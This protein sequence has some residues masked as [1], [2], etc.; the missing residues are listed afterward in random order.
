MQYF[1]ADTHFKHQN[2]LRLSNRPFST[3]EEHDE[4]LIKNWN[5]TVTKNDEVYILGDFTMSRKGKD[6][7][8]LLKRLNGK[9]YLIKGN[10]EHY[11]NDPEFDMSN[12][13]WVKDYFEFH[14]NKIQFVLFHYPILEWNGFFQKSIHLYGHVHNTRPEYFTETLDPRAINVGVDMINFKPIAIT[15]IVDYLESLPT[16][17]R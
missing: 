3:I 5:A 4:T 13:E 1:I 8:A 11:L 12:Y 9:K 15:E 7:N 6:A 10:H 17:N 14:Y 2:I 16:P